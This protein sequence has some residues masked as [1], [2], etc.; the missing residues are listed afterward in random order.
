LKQ[1]S[2]HLNKMTAAR[3]VDEDDRN[4]FQPRLTTVFLFFLSS[5][6]CSALYNRIIDCDEP[7][8]YWEPT[9]FLMFGN[10]LQTW[11]YSPVYALRSYAYLLYHSSFGNVL[12]MIVPNNTLIL[13]IYMKIMIGLQTAL[14]QTVFYAGIQRK[15]GNTIALYTALFMLFSPGMFISSTTYLPSTF[16]MMTLLLAYGFW[17]LD[18]P[19]LAVFMC[20]TSVF[21][22]WPFVIVVCVPIALHLLVRHG[23]LRLVAWALL[24]CALVLAPMLAIDYQYYG[25]FVFAI[26]NIITYNFTASHAG[27]SQL[28]GIEH[29]SFYFINCFVNFNVVF[30]AALV[31]APLVVLLW[32]TPNY[33]GT[34]QDVPR[35]LLTLSP[36]YMWFAFM[37]YLPHK[38]ERFLF[39]VYPFLCLAAATAI[40]LC[41]FALGRL[42]NKY[43]EY[44]HK[45]NDGDTD[46]LRQKGTSRVHARSRSFWTSALE[47]IITFVQYTFVLLFIV[48][49]IS[50]TYS[51][52]INYTGALD[53]FVHLHDQVLKGGNLAHPDFP[54][55]LPHGG[56][57]RVCVGKEWY[58][59]PS[60][61]FL[62]KPQLD[63]RSNLG[64]LESHFKGQLPQPFASGPNA[65]SIIPSN[66]NDQNREERDR[67]VPVESCHYII[68]F[69]LPTDAAA[70]RYTKR[71]DFETV[72]S[73]PFMDAAHS[74][75]LA[76][77]FY[78]PFYSAD[79]CTFHNYVLLSAK[80]NNGKR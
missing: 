5:A 38:E 25:K 54:A 79:H 20:A 11:E 35:T 27:G 16:S 72:F 47:T 57:V 48:L 19:L 44:L 42:C 34:L 26:L 51:T 22:G 17:M 46:I 10:G 71:D 31:A 65:T 15:F 36:F 18:R 9:H 41:T 6:V 7:M 37:S 4:V 50:R 66:F 78:I 80:S 69:D 23:P 8:N 24:P 13:Y 59:F 30:V 29:W 67:Y 63:T 1:T 12:K 74:S 60:N 55:G 62:P 56:T 21:M 32:L 76:R 61:Y 49:S 45:K 75:S 39:V 70:D 58:R 53:T 28:Y 73:A 43:D 2:T 64:F 40:Y 77:A 33:R 3:V 52:Y 14:G 68:D